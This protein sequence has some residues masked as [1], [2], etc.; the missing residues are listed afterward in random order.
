MARGD[1]KIFQDFAKKL[2]EGS[3]NLSSAGLSLSFVADT[4]ATV[5]ATV[6]NPNISGFTR[7]SGGN[8]P[9]NTALSGVTWTRSG[10]IITLD[11]ADPSTIASAAGNPTTARTALIHFTT[12]G[13]LYKAIDLTTDGTTALDLVNNDF[14]YTVNAS[15]SATLTV[16]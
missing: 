13:D 15:G 7:L 3:Y 1:S 11:Y 8:V 14:S 6:N 4:Y 16:A 5:D 12:G 2:G 10:A 9:S